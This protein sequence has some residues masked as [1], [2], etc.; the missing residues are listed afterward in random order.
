MN[1]FPHTGLRWSLP[2]RLARMSL[3]SVSLDCLQCRIFYIAAVFLC[4]CEIRNLL[5]IRKLKAA[6]EENERVAT[7]MT[8][9]KTMVGE[10]IPPE[11]AVQSYQIFEQS[12]AQWH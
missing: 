11:T 5:T 10:I 6:P 8:K 12:R 7:N 9:T 1:T 4:C 2:C 3:H